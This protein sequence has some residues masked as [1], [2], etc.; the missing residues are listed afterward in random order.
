[1]NEYKRQENA[2]RIINTCFTYGAKLQRNPMSENEKK[3]FKLEE[4]R[5]LER[6]DSYKLAWFLKHKKAQSIGGYVV[7][8]KNP[9]VLG[10]DEIIK[11]K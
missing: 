9:F 8:D 4:K 11:K 1:M 6:F 10:W 7:G 3:K 5:E 2:F